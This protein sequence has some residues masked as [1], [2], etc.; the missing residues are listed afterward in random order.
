MLMK[1]RT[2]ALTVIFVVLSTIVTGT[3]LADWVGNEKQ[4]ADYTRFLFQLEK[5]LHC[6]RLNQLDIS[7]KGLLAC[8]TTY[9]KTAGVRSTS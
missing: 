8:R 5:N 6:N 1:G 7:T 4:Q 2:F 3:L 9:G